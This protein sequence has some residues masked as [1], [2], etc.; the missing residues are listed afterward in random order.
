[1]LGNINAATNVLTM[2]SAI[3]QV[4]RKSQCLN[5]LSSNSFN[6]Y[7]GVIR[8]LRAYESPCILN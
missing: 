5:R 3:N 1:M 7:L 2:T 4:A 6:A 8:S